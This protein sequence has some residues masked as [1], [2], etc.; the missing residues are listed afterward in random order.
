MID[1]IK[2]ML[3]VIVVFFIGYTVIPF[4]IDLFVTLWSI[5]PWIDVFLLLFVAVGL[6]W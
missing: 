4:I 2:F 3:Y 5:D 1:G 6:L